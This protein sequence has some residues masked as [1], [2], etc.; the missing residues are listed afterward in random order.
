MREIHGFESSWTRCK[1]NFSAL[2]LAR[3]SVEQI[4]EFDPRGLSN[5]AWSCA[6]L[7]CRDGPLLSAVWAAATP[8]MTEFDEQALSTTLWALAKL[9]EHKAQCSRPGGE[10]IESKKGHLW[11]VLP[12][13]KFRK[14]QLLKEKFLADLC[15]QS[16]HQMRDF[17]AQNLGNFAWALAKLLVDDAPIMAQISAMA[18]QKI[19]LCGHQELG[20]IAWAFT[21]LSIRE[22]PLL[23]AIA[24]ESQRRMV[25]FNVQG[26]ANSAWALA[27]VSFP[28]QP[29]FN[30]V[31]AA[32]QRSMSEWDPQAIANL[33]WSFATISVLDDPLMT[34]ISLRA[35]CI[36]DC[37]MM[38]D[39]KGPVKV[40]D[41][42]R[43]AHEKTGVCTSPDG[44]YIVTGTSL[45]KNALGA[46]TLRVYDTKTLSL[47]KSLDFGKKSVL[48]LAWPK[49]LNQILVSTTAGDVVMLYSPFSLRSTKSAFSSLEEAGT[50][51][52]FNMTDPDEI[53][54]FYSTGHGDMYRIRR[55]EARAAQKTLTPT[56]P[57]EL[58]SESGT[59]MPDQKFGDFAAL[60]LKAGAQTLHLNSTRVTDTDSQKALLEYQ[61]KISA[62]KSSM[63]VDTAYSKTQPTKILDFSEDISEGDKRMA[64][65]MRGE[66]C[67]SHGARAR[68]RSDEDGRVGRFGSDR[69]QG[70]VN[71]SCFG[72]CGLLRTRV[73][74]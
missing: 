40:F 9:L 25:E 12:S 28:H 36:W 56:R 43:T 59:K 17:G 66:F 41:D 64:L 39:A 5:S 8:R 15:H 30:S 20:N 45:S 34:A 70:S 14:I 35:V 6:T 24:V 29:F 38:S 1:L 31:S 71:S 33:S 51:P 21:T 32:A 26:M 73:A 23:E 52:I 68:G 46:A 74:Q 3:R 13:K 72:F 42:L 7:R 62:A 37:R 63:L 49:D 48:R 2:A 57:E 22:L 61:D 44:R 50:G 10:F 55:S 16:S 69:L 65:A 4:W 47:T 11:R 18:R 53:K 19:R 27:K 54:K 67:R 58:R 60:A